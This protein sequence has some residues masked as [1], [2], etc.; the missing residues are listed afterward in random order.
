[1]NMIAEAMDTTEC[2]LDGIYQTGKRYEAF[3]KGEMVYSGY[4]ERSAEVAIEK[5]LGTW[6]RKDKGQGRVAKSMYKDVEESKFS[7]NERFGFLEKAVTMVADGVQPSVVISGAG[8]LGKTYTVRKA[9]EK[10][11]LEDFTMNTQ[12]EDDIDRRDTFIFIKGFSTPKALYRS[13]WANNDSVIVFDD[14]DSVLENG[15][16]LNI[17]KAALDSYDKRIISWG[18][19]LRTKGEDDLPQRFEFTGQIIFITNHD[20]DE[21]DQA[22]RSRSLMIDVSMTLEETVERMSEIIKSRAFLP[23]YSKQVKEDA[24]AFID[25]FKDKAKELSLRSL[26]TVCKMRSEFEDQDWERMSEYV[27]CGQ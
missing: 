13:L 1:M 27:L 25:L 24:I 21:I 3:V 14:C 8:G 10:S 26:I 22:I 17:L 19:E 20:A 23:E 12:E 7:I 5:K 2:V 16:A 9:L 15:T 6:T 18:A 4:I 11:G